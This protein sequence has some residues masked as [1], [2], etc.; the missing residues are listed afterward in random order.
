MSVVMKIG[1]LMDKPP[2][3]VLTDLSYAR[4]GFCGIAQE[5]RLLLKA[6][7]QQ[8]RIEPTGLIFRRDDALF[9]QRFQQNPDLDEEIES[10]ALFWRTF[11]DGP[12]VFSTPKTRQGLWRIRWHRLRTAL[13]RALKRPVTT[14]SLLH[15]THFWDLVW[16]NLLERSLSDEDLPIAQDC[17][18]L[19]ANVGWPKSFSVWRH[20][21][22]KLDTTGYDFVL[23]HN[24]TPIQVSRGT[25]KLVRYY[26]MIPGV[27]PDFM[28]TEQVI[29]KHF[30]EVLSCRED[31]VFVCISEAARQDLIS[32][33]PDLEARS[34]SIPVVLSDA[35]YAD[36]QPLR[37][38]QILRSRQS[39]RIARHPTGALAPSVA[40]GEVPRY[41]IMTSTLE[42]RKNYVYLTKA[43]ER[44]VAGKNS[45]LRLVV[46]GNP[47][48]KSDE[49][50]KA[51][52]P[53]IE[54][55]LLYHLERVP[56]EELRILYSH[57]QALVFPS[58]YEGF[59][60]TPLEAM[61]CETPAVVSDIAA[62]R[63]VYG[64]AALYCDP[65]R[66]QSLV[67]QVE[68][69]LSPTA[70]GLRAE[71]VDRG[72]QR[73]QRYLPDAVGPLW[74]ELFEHL[75]FKAMRSSGRFLKAA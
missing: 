18:I 6:L 33:F 49:I 11:M 17:P 64:D 9:G 43:F 12:P 35:Y 47:G 2:Y 32:V 48:W 27:R 63:E 37:C 13:K 28:E 59:G 14:T 25:F 4:L 24:A 29:H 54:R 3:R 1:G 19:L 16:R 65:Y 39:E 38:V 70:A 62:H 61:C 20:C 40:S 34:F 57:A 41:L 58:L 31:S 51:M 75:R 73:V 74:V 67:D 21:R 44:L 15:R 23:F 56:T 69:L 71:L 42:P 8:P 5:S 52:K 66:P 36:R 7:W 50:T 68:A 46:V 55:G 72:K 60:Y 45:D 22:A 30:H 53:L 10:Q 26:D